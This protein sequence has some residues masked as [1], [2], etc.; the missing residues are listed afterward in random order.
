MLILR[1]DLGL[2]AKVYPH[3]A[4]QHG[5]AVQHLSD[6]DGGFG[7][8][9]AHDDAAE[10]LE[11]GECV[12]QGVLVDGGADAFEVGAGEDLGGL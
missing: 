9:E 4:A 6:V 2:L 3:P 10:G 1:D 8:V 7:G 5:L 11:R 12:D